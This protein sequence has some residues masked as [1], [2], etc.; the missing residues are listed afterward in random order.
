MNSILVMGAA[1]VAQI[2]ALSQGV[3]TNAPVIP[4]SKKTLRQIRG[5]RFFSALVKKVL[6][7]NCSNGSV[8]L[9]SQIP[10]L[11]SVCLPSINSCGKAA[12]K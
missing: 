9:F 8:F 5:F 12:A 4:A 10:S 2:N 6:A 7:V 1:G 11:K 3:Q